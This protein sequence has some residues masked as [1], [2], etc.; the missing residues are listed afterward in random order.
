MLSF[1]VTALF[2][3]LVS[4]VASS[5]LAQGGINKRTASPI[6][7]V[8]ATR[9]T[10][11]KNAVTRHFEAAPS[12]NAR[13]LLSHEMAKFIPDH[14]LPM[15]AYLGNRLHSLPELSEVDQQAL[16]DQMMSEPK[17]RDY[18]VPEHWE[19][20]S[21]EHKGVI[22]IDSHPAA[23]YGREHDRLIEPLEIERIRT[24][25]NIVGAIAARTAENG[26]VDELFALACKSKNADSGEC[27]TY[28]YVAVEKQ[29]FGLPDYAHWVAEAFSANDLQRVHSNVVRTIG[30]DGGENLIFMRSAFL[31]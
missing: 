3:L 7:P 18:F 30:K 10:I 16:V 2:S 25:L 12:F 9:N 23:L 8:D 17:I 29:G 31:P 15:G 14:G 4:L 20:G 22:K 6:P 26:F 24:Q 11:L 28:Q 19:E 27:E 1:R 21:L 13:Y 5:A